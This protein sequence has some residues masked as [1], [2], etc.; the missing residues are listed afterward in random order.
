MGLRGRG[1]GLGKSGHGVWGNRI[2]GEHKGFFVLRRCC[3]GF[4]GG[5]RSRRK[6]GQGVWGVWG[7]VWGVGCLGGSG[8]GGEGVGLGFRAKSS[9][10]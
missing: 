7:G 2:P 6:S 4:G 3:G 9:L 1:E 5:R 8:G 10:W